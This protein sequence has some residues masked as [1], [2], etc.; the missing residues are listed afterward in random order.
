MD[1]KRREDGK[2]DRGGGEAICGREGARHEQLASDDGQHAA[3]D[4]EGSAVERRGE[5][6]A[7]GV[8]ATYASL[9]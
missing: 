4:Q 2:D 8:A 9:L 7:E 6:D 1:G 5:D 3:Q